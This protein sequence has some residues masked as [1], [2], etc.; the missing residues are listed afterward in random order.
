M[1]KGQEL[2]QLQT[3]ITTPRQLVQFWAQSGHTGNDFTTVLI[4]YGKQEIVNSIT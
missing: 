4:P 2:I 3:C 1:A